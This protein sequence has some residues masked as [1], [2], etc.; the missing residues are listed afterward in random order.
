MAVCSFWDLQCKGKEAAEA[1][2]N[3]ILG[4]MADMVTKAQTWVIKASVSWWV[5]IPSPDL[6]SGPSTTLQQ[7]MLPFAVLIATGGILWQALLMIISRKGEP[8]LAIV[9]GLFTTAVWGAVG[10]AGANMLLKFSD[11][12]AAWILST[13]LDGHLD[14]LP[15]RLILPA[16]TA[17]P[18]LTIIVG[19]VVVLASCVQALML[20]GRN[21]AVIILAGLLQLAAAGSFTTGTSNWLRRILTWILSLIFYKDF[22]ATAYAVSFMLIGDQA[23]ND[24]RVWFS[25]IVTLGLSIVALP[26]TMRFFNWTVGAVQSNGNSAGMLAAAGAA[27]MHAVA[28]RR[29]TSSI[30]VTD[31]AR[32]MDRR[33]SPTG[34]GRSGSGTPRPTPPIFIGPALAG[35]SMATGPAAP[36]VAGATAGAKVAGAAV[37]TAKD[38]A[39]N[40]TEEQ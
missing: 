2:T 28:S 16:S 24:P 17:P 15:Q 13:G 22:A 27:G 25:G 8:L 18:G 7:W 35:S 4:Q 5:D 21:G 39:A 33:Y 30:S 37:R 19:T 36:I 12:Y 11:S 29:G 10:I 9:K 3:S 26:A 14:Q 31:Y 1:A 6:Q 38:A 34:N 20:L 40:P 32:D 23:S